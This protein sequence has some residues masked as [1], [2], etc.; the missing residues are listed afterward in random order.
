MRNPLS[1]RGLGREVKGT[2]RHGEQGLMVK[3]Q[4]FQGWDGLPAGRRETLARAVSHGEHDV[5]VRLPARV[6][7]ID[8]HAIAD[9]EFDL[10]RLCKQVTG[11][12]ATGDRFALVVEHQREMRFANVR[13]IL[14]EAPDRGV[15]DGR[16][17]IADF[18]VQFVAADP[19]KYG[20]TRSH[21]ET[22]TATTIDAF[23]YGNFPA[24][25]VIEIPSAPS[26]YT[27]T[28]P[29]GTFTVT[30]ATAGG[31]H[32]IDM[33]TGRVT[34]DGVWMP[35]V[36]GGPLW[37]V[38]DGEAWTHTLSVPGRVLMTDTDV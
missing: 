7:T 30:G 29:G 17:F 37:A 14:R 25:P 18:Q 16:T 2:L 3:P 8:G 11:W 21:P 32:Q 15:R 36:G 13:S 10:G 28:S 33:R 22:G 1:I 31:T 34:R 4:G 23:H 35:G 6:I 5:P 26:S 27:V 9:S 12:G 19:R 38:P 20:E 24:H